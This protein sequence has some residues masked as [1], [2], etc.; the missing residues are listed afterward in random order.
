MNVIYIHTHDLGDWTS[1]L[2]K[3]VETPNL[4]ALASASTVF[5]NAHSAAP[6]CSP[7]RAALLTGTTPHQA[8][9]LGLA[10]RGFSLERTEYH[11]ANV[12]QAEGYATALCG[13]QHEFSGFDCD[14]FPYEEVFGQ[15]VRT[16]DESMDAFQ[17]RR[18]REIAAEAAEWLKAR[19]KD[20]N[21]F[22]SVGFFQP[23]RPLLDPDDGFEV[24]DTEI[25]DKLPLSDETSRDTAALKTSVRH[26]DQC[27][28]ILLEA[29]KSCGQWEQSI[30]LF[31]TDHGIAFPYHKCSLTDQG[32]HVALMLRHPG[33]PETHG[34]RVEAMVSHLDVVPTLYE[35][36]G[37]KVPDWCGGISLVGLIAGEVPVVR[38]TLYSEVNYHAAYE[39]MRSIR[40]HRHRL[41]RRFLS[42]GGWVLANVD[43]SLS[44]DEWLQM[45][46]FAEGVR[47]YE[48][49]D[50][51]ADPFQERNVVDDPGY[52]EILADLNGRLETWMRETDDPLL[53]GPVRRPPHS[54][55]N[56]RDSFSPHEPFF[57]E[58]SDEVLRLE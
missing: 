40:T 33:C 53:Y 11:L 38:D 55:V 31:T 56:H 25:P 22:L 13:I 42:D 35:W 4:E 52:G 51:S 1:V 27:V 21:F 49:Y 41:V 29:L 20:G 54:R 47:E 24:C 32:T 36:L 48:L 7:S 15:I 10:H 46:V 43:D 2:G 28:G 44:K 17:R 6:T 39:P 58:N 9:M 18:D 3:P 45:P 8:G 19:K 12:L 23:H 14:G 50:L 30:I 5:T 37:M 26:L 16:E 57:E 34:R